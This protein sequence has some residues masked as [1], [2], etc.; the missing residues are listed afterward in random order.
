M[1]FITWKSASVA[2][3]VLAFVFGACSIPSGGS[4][5]APQ[6]ETS[7]TAAATPP[8][9]STSTPSP[10]QTSLPDPAGGV[11]PGGS[12]N[13]EE[14]ELPAEPLPVGPDGQTLDPCLYGTW[15]VE[16]ES[17]A[18]YLA[19]ALNQGGTVDF[20]SVPEITGLMQM[21]FDEQG[22]MTVSS[23]DYLI[24]LLFAPSDALQIDIDMELAAN[25]T[26]TYQADGEHL[27]NF[28]R[29]ISVTGSPL[30]SVLQAIQ[31]GETVVVMEVTPEWFLGEV[32]EEGGEPAQSSYTCAGDSLTIT[33][34][35]YGPW[36]LVRE[37]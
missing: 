37:E 4:E 29:D 7:P 30:D 26:A 5:P 13:G 16:N 22:E 28:N 1:K 14:D 3:L 2:V 8:D 18:Q 24:Y 9:E 27:T 32:S 33:S 6:A 35:E 20:F 34:N 17:V 15:T 11:S 19:T 31:D 25:G 21:S 23:E 36:M 12:G 10:T